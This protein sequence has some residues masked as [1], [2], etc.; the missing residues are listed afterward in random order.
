MSIDPERRR[1]RKQDVAERASAA[2]TTH[3]CGVEGCRNLTRASAR[4]GLNNRYCK[5][6]EEH[7]QR[8]GSPFRGSYGADWLN[9]YRRAAFDWLTANPDN[10]WVKNAIAGVQ[11]LYQG[12]GQAVEA[13]R[14]RGLKPEERAR[15]HGHAFVG[16]RSTH[17]SRLPL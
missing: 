14:L 7:H 13:F 1:R 2:P 12:A 5:A 17:A 8:H 10:L 15:R 16:T 4:K 6:H 9:P 11:G 3:H